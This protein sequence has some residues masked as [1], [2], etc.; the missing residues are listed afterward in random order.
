MTNRCNAACIMCPREKQTRDQG[1]MSMDMF[2]DV[3]EQLTDQDVEAVSLENYGEPYVDKFLFDRAAMIKDRGLKAYTITTGSLLHLKD[4]ITNTL[5]Y[6]DKLR[7]SNYATTKEVYEKVHKRLKFETV[8]KNLT[9]LFSAREESDSNIRIEMYFL[10]LKENSH[11]TNDWIHL[12]ESRADFISIW[13]PH[14]WGDGRS[15]RKIDKSNRRSCGRP[16]NGPLQ[17]QWDGK[18]V[19]CCYDY[20][21]QIVLG[22]LNEDTI[23]EVYNSA[24][25]NKLRNAHREKKFEQFKFCHECDQLNECSG[26]LVYTNIPEVAVGKTN[27]HYTSLCSQ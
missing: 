5:K 10:S 8:D 25:Y 14:N 3:L 23:D 21:S 17:V 9:D 22:D 19:P 15:Y 20:N 18:I 27:T 2:K 4:N 7:I 13:K 16:F 24:E 1:T 26:S 12:N 6:F 11:Q